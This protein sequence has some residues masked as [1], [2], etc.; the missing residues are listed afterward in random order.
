ML[1]ITLKNQWLPG[2]AR[3]D[4]PLTNAVLPITTQS[5]SQEGRD[6]G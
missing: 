1:R 2:Q 5:A 3:N 6:D 4:K